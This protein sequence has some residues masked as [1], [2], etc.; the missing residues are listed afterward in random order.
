MTS[1]IRMFFIVTVMLLTAC[2]VPAKTKKV[3]RVSAKA[4]LVEAY[5]RERL[6]GTSEGQSETSTFIVIVWRSS[7][8]P[9]SFFWRGSGGWL[10]CKTEKARKV[11]G[12]SKDMPEGVDYTIERIRPDAIKTGDTLLLTVLKGGKFP[13][14]SE[15]KDNVQNTLFFKTNGSKWLPLAVK[16]VK[17]KQPIAMP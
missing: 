17:K 6:A 5:T 15:I 3:K 14:P 12:G 1:V 16:T 4:E 8:Y 10:P 9:E 2:S 13:I 7:T 11:I